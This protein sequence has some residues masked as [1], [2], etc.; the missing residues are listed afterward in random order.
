MY[1][2]RTLEP[3]VL[4]TGDDQGVEPVLSHGCTHVP[5]APL[6]LNC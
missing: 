4:V 5:V 6:E 1:V 3:A 2:T